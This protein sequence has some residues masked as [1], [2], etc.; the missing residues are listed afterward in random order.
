MHG[1]EPTATLAIA[2]I[3]RLVTADGEIGEL[4]RS[5]LENLSLAFFPMVNPD[6]ARRHMRHNALGIDINRDARRLASPE[7]RL[8]MGLHRSVRPHFAFNLHD[9]ILSSAGAAARPTVLALLAPPPDGHGSVPACRRR[10]M[11]VGAS[12]VDALCEEAS[13]SIA[14]YEDRYERRAFGDAFQALGTS[15]LLIESGHWPRNPQRE[16]VRSLTVAAILAGLRSLADRSFRTADIRK[17]TSLPPNGAWVFNVIVRHVLLRHRS[18]WSGLVD[19]G[20]LT[21]KK[22]RPGSPLLEIRE[23]GDLTQFGA[24]ETVD[25]GGRSLSPSCVLPGRTTSLAQLLSRLRPSA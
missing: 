25:A 5:L 9:Q 19:V 13:G 11:L 7:A 16:R 2:D 15:T 10:A 22:N 20:L 14:A 17:Y 24:I 4:F 1:D 8:L 18:G 23:V 21:P 12:I 3:L 6:G